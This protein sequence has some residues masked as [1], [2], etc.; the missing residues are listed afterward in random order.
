LYLG[1]DHD[2]FN[3]KYRESHRSAARVEFGYSESDFV[4]VLVGNDLR[5]KGIRALVEAMQRLR[6][7]RVRLLVATRDNL[8]PFEKLIR[9]A[10]VADRIQFLPPRADVAYYYAAADAYA[11]PSLEDTFALPPV[12]AMA[13]GIP[14][15]VS[16]ENGT[17]EIIE[18]RVNGMILEDPADSESLAR[19]LLEMASDPQ[20][21][22][23]LGDNGADTARKLTWEHNVDEVRRIFSKVLIH[24]DH[25]DDVADPK[26]TSKA[27]IHADSK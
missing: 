26:S 21:A 9:T 8:A 10:G 6:E 20:L 5:K 15:L 13:C 18:H 24:R 19:M 7:S 14:V 11:G 3:Q 22:A 23:R 16:R 25:S 2:V 12:E 1:L 4:V 17:V 27:G